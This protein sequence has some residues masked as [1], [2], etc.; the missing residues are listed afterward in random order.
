M[1]YKW[2]GNK[3]DIK[4]YRP[5]T[6]TSPVYGLAVQIIKKRIKSC[7]GGKEVLGELQNSFRKRRRLEDNLFT[8]T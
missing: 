6:V 5:I 1:I 7:V 8:L 2:K 4:S 3:H